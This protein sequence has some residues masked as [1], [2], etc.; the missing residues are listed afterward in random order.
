MLPREELSFHTSKMSDPP[1]N[2]KFS[3][4]F[5][6]PHVS[7]WNRNLV[8]LPTHSLQF[9]NTLS[10]TGCS[11]TVWFEIKLHPVVWSSCAALHLAK[12]SCSWIRLSCLRDRSYFTVIMQLYNQYISIIIYCNSMQCNEVHLKLF[13]FAVVP[14]CSNSRTATYHNAYAVDY[15]RNFKWWF[16]IKTTITKVTEK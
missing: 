8:F 2:C 10:T 6:L 11:F 15:E 5:C 4:T 14:Q 3:W 12:E 7:N 1:K 13:N 16:S 9:S